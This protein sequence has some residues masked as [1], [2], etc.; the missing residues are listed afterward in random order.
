MHNDRDTWV[1][2]QEIANKYT[3]DKQELS[4]LHFSS[5]EALS[6]D[7]LGQCLIPIDIFFIWSV[8]N[9]GKDEFSAKKSVGDGNSLYHSSSLILVGNEDL[10][11]LL[12]LLTAIKLFLHASLY[13]KG[14]KHWMKKVFR[15]FNGG[16]HS[17]FLSFHGLMNSINWPA[18]SIWVFIVQLGEHCSAN[19]EATGS[20]PVEAPKNFFSGYFHNCLNCDSLRWSHTHFICIPAVHIISFNFISLRSLHLKLWE[21][22]KKLELPLFR[23]ILRPS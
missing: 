3:D 15:G 7:D 10:H 5:W 21:N 12:R 23:P 9:N 19:A 20:N 4:K 2:I 6:W 17:V 11:L 22:K 1:L 16:F 18:C 13:V 14:M 8:K